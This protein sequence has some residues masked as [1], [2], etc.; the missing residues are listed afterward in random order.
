MIDAKEPRSQW[1]FGRIKNS[2][3][4][5]RCLCMAPVALKQQP[6]V[7][8][9][10]FVVPAYRAL[11]A[12]RPSPLDECLAT[13]LL[14]AVLRKKLLQTE[15]LLKLNFVFSHDHSPMYVGLGV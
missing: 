14:V 6:G 9:T 5:D 1:Q 10:V 13:L 12:L 15:T 2:S 11:K 3:G 8:L 4:S 7:Q